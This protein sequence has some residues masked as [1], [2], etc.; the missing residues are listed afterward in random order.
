MTEHAAG[1]P[2]GAVVNAIVLIWATA[3]FYYLL[4]YVLEEYVDPGGFL[5]V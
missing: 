2:G 1:L 4:F 5:R 3:R